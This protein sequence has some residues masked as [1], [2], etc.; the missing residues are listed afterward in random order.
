MTKQQEAMRVALGALILA[1][2]AIEPLTGAQI[3]LHRLPNETPDKIDSAISLLSAAVE[4][5]EGAV[6]T[7]YTIDGDPRQLGSDDIHIE[8]AKQ[9]YGPAKWAVR[10][11][12]EC[13]NKSG[14]W[15][16]EPMPSSRDDEFLERC[17][18]ASAEEAIRHAALAAAPQKGS[19]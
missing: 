13:L 7:K 19:A 9:I 10:R 4:E 2:R 5:G 8:R 3:K 6:V 17:R 11:M 1:R 18:F 12:G 15:E 16:W 14:E